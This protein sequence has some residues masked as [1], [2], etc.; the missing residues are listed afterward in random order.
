M[1]APR[2][3]FIFTSN[4]LRFGGAERQRVTVANALVEQGEEV[5]LHLLKSDAPMDLRP[6]L[7]PRVR[8]RLEPW[9]ALP[10][11]GAG[12]HLLVTGSTQTELAA[13]LLW[14]LRH[15][16]A[17]RWVVAHHHG[18]YRDRATFTPRL[19]RQMRFADGAIYLAESHRSDL[20]ARHRLDRGRYWIVPNGSSMPLTPPNEPRV[21]AIGSLRIVSVGRVTRSKRLDIVLEALRS[22]QGV[23]WTFDIFGG[24]DDIPRLQRMAEN[25]PSGRVRFRGW[26]SEPAAALP[27]YDLF[28]LPS[29]LEAQP[30]VILES[31]AAGVPVMA[32]TAG[33]S[34]EMVGG[35]AGIVVQSFSP[36]AWREAL[37]AYACLPG[38]RRGSLARA[39][40]RR[41]TE[42]YTVDGMMSG[43]CR[44]YDDLLPS[45]TS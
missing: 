24:G 6:Q 18:A 8:L 26:I 32:S 38:E 16:H 7:D 30:M 20:L 31:M 43:Y 45:R 2:R 42:R 37:A 25:L 27:A 10:A 13:G 4:D 15:L 39:A 11:G 9:H 23:D 21:D 19:A 34:P 12:P 14:R 41:L 44:L 22:L 29:E 33:A 35:G 1:T 17:G 36:D 28:V 3:R 5:V 40:Q